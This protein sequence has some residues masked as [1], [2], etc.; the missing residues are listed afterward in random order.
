VQAAKIKDK[1]HNEH[2]R[3]RNAECRVKIERPEGA[4]GKTQSAERIAES[5]TKNSKC[6]L[7]GDRVDVSLLVGKIRIMAKEFSKR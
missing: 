3:L 1:N 6:K 5:E 2:C 4:R 7:L